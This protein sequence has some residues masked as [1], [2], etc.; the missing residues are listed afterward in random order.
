MTED[1]LASSPT[2]STSTVPT[3]DRGH[4]VA[5]TAASRRHDRTGTARSREYRR[6][7]REGLVPIMLEIRGEEIAAMAQ[8]RVLRAEDRE[9]K[10]AVSA[11][12]YAILDAAFRALE[13]G[14]LLLRAP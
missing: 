11:A 4:A 8:Q 2:V 10:L 13:E 5:L 7:K 14:S 1:L 9:D 6:R 3:S 12:L